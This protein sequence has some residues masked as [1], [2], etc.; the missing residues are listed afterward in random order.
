MPAEPPEGF[1]VIVEPHRRHPS[2][3]KRAAIL[4][5]QRGLCLYCENSFGTAVLRGGKGIVLRVV[6]DHFAPF[7]VF[8]D[9]TDENFVAACQV[10]NQ[11]KGARIF[12][13]VAEA[14]DWLRRRWGKEGI[15]VL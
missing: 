1:K 2:P 9:T 4:D 5:E 15:E 10:C 7:S 14:A 3:A 11:F 12:Q 8:G 13:T 6:W